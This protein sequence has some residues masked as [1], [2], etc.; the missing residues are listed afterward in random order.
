MCSNEGIV[1]LVLSVVSFV[2]V[3]L[4][5]LSVLDVTTEYHDSVMST[6]YKEVDEDILISTL[7]DVSETVGKNKGLLFVQSGYVGEELYYRVM[8]TDEVKSKY[9]KLKANDTFL[10]TISDNEKPFIRIHWSV[11][12]RDGEV[13]RSYADHRLD[14]FTDVV[15]RI[16]GIDLYVPEGTV[17]KGF[18]I[19]FE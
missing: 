4:C 9:Y 8:L 17:D 10:Y 3:T 6:E 13:L 12:Y 18:S 15:G 2:V 5:L 16:V 14:G 11:K 7:Y 1:R 19:D